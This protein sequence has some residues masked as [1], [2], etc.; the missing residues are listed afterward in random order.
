LPGLFR[1]ALN[2]EFTG[3]PHILR[4]FLESPTVRAAIPELEI[5]EQPKIPPHACV[6]GAFEWEGTLTQLLL[7]DG[8]YVRSSLQEEEARKLSLEFVDVVSGG[9]RDRMIVF[10]WSGPWTE[11]F[12]DVAWD[13]TSVVLNSGQGEEGW[14]VL[15]VTDTD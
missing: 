2:G 12:Y 9:D 13:R 11:W 3:L 1:E 8:A 7:A 15:C 10:R 6:L 14:W 4:C 5:P